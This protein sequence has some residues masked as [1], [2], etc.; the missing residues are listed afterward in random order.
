MADTFTKDQRSQIMRQVKSS[1]NKSTEI[2]LIQLFK[3]LSI[4]GWRRNYKI[5]GKPDFIFPEVRIAIFIDGCFWHGH[6]CRNTKPKDNQ[7]YW[8]QKINRNI[9][10][11][12]IVNEH[13]TNKGWT[14]IR[15]WE[16]E[17]KDREILIER[18]KL[19]NT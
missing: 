10:R 18:L 13:L 1:R 15:L 9:Q 8:T 16:C 6:N 17:L 11:D 12:N 2:R 19:N 3:N 4:K 14:V 7:E 5:F